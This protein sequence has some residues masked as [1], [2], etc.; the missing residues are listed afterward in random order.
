MTLLGDEDIEI[1]DQQSQM[2]LAPGGRV[3]EGDRDDKKSNVP[4]QRDDGER[5]GGDDPFSRTSDPVRMYLRKMGT[6]PLL[7]REGEVEIAKKIEA[8]EL[9]VLKSL[10]RSPIVI[11][12]ILDL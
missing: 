3:H 1:V 11:K 7:T 6:V 9:R 2:K 8:G 12:E 4:L 5:E 10:T